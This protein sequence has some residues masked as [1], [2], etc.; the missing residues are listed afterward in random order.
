MMKDHGSGRDYTGLFE[1]S[2][3]LCY[4]GWEEPYNDWLD[5]EEERI[6]KKE[7][8]ENT[9]WCPD[10]S[11]PTASPPIPAPTQAPT[12][13]CKRNERPN[14]KFNLKSNGKEFDCTEVGTRTLKNQRKLCNR[15]IITSNGKIRRLHKKCPIT[16]GNVGVGECNFLKS[17]KTAKRERMLKSTKT[18]EQNQ[19]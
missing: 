14:E 10:T 19:R 4:D 15:K 16:C 5:S 18:Q 8:E 3:E 17:T 2:L 11:A 6:Q 1:W 9:P 13:V 12:H 7:E